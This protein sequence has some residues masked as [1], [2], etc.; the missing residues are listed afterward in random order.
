MHF[1]SSLLGLDLTHPRRNLLFAVGSAVLIII[2]I[3]VQNFVGNSIR[4]PLIILAA[5]II[6]A[7]AIYKVPTVKTLRI[8]DINDT[9]P[10][11]ILITALSSY[12]PRARNFEVLKSLIE[13][14]ARDDT[15][16]EIYLISTLKRDKADR[17]SIL[18]I[19]DSNREGVPRMYRELVHY[20]NSMNPMPQY[21]L[22]PI[23]DA[24]HYKDTKDQVARLLKTLAGNAYTPDQITIDIT[25]GT[26]PMSVGLAIAG[27]EADC[28][29]TYQASRRDH[30]G[31][32]TEEVTPTRLST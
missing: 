16:Q 15:L 27:F 31:I 19:D 2:S 10:T 8:K 6:F 17:L 20:L 3:I 7:Y 1:L 12:N 26:A 28:Q 29:V 4:L 9:I 25:S 32:P 22:V 24:Y 11:P 13:Q 5:L 18:E 21:H 30:E 14:H 23:D